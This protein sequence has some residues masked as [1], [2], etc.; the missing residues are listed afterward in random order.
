MCQQP[1]A[2]GKKHTKIDE[3]DDWEKSQVIL[4]L[5]ITIRTRSM[6]VMGTL[7][8]HFGSLLMLPSRRPCSIP[9]QCLQSAFCCDGREANR[10]YPALRH[11]YHL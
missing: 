2:F 6:Y 4:F 7:C 1:Y 5:L 11:E 3:S 9:I 8:C 10:F